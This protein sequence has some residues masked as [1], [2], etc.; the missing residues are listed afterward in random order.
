MW[1][2]GQSNKPSEI[3]VI[4]III[5]VKVI[6]NSTMHRI[7]FNNIHNIRSGS[8]LISSENQHTHRHGYTHAT[9]HTP[10]ATSATCNSIKKFKVQRVSKMEARQKTVWWM[11][12]DSPAEAS[13]NG[14][15]FDTLEMTVW[16]EHEVKTMDMQGNHL[17][18]LTDQFYMVKPF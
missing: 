9:F 17:N 13:S 15:M 6:L 2:A 1:L 11:S 3:L 10:H 7:V 4:I 5:I 18:S 12:S 16:H 8:Q 14:I